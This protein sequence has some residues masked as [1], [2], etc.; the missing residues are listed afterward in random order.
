MRFG[1]VVDQHNGGQSP[2]IAA[3]HATSPLPCNYQEYLAA[4][5]H[6]WAMTQAQLWSDADEFPDINAMGGEQHPSA[7]EEAWRASRGRDGVFER[8]PAF[9]RV[10]NLTGNFGNILAVARDQLSSRDN[11]NMHASPPSVTF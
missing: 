11:W 4:Q 5:Q 6:L 1:C 10:Q 3:R 9:R 2:N 8:H 7:L